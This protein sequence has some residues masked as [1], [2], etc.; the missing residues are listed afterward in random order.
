GTIPSIMSSNGADEVDTDWVVV[1]RGDLRHS[2]QK[3]KAQNKN[4]L[5]IFPLRTLDDFLLKSA[6]F[7]VPNF[8]HL[9][10]W[11]NRVIQ[12]LL[13]YQTNYFFTY[14]IALIMLIVI[15]PDK[16]IFGI[17][18]LSTS[19]TMFYHV[20]KYTKSLERIYKEHPVPFVILTVII[21]Y[22]IIIPFCFSLLLILGILL[23][24][25][26]LLLLGEFVGFTIVFLLDFLW[27]VIYLL[28]YGII[29]PVLII[30]IHASLRMRNLKNKM[31]NTIE[32]SGLVQTPMG[33]ILAG[34][35]LE[36]NFS[37]SK[38]N[39]CGTINKMNLRR[40]ISLN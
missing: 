27:S 21:S 2:T 31:I 16:V 8:N 10:K 38:L 14:L 5:I 24:V 29:L 22:S 37:M 17:F 39:I 7:D 4:E 34:L 6:R 28:V 15:H 13:Y 20:M 26:K 11:E 32:W 18:A 30:L 33:Y 36:Q 40:L 25:L 19:F 1:N 35:G 3:E 12:N 9:Q 23:P